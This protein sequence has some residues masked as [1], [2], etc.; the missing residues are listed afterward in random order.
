[1]RRTSRPSRSRPKCASSRKGAPRW[2]RIVSKHPSPQ[3][4]PRFWIETRASSSGITT[5]S[6]HAEAVRRHLHPVL[7]EGLC[8]SAEFVERLPILR[9]RLRI[10]DNA[11]ADREIG[12]FADHRCGAYRDV[13]IDRA[14]PGDIANRPC[15]HAAAVRLQPLDDLHGPRLRGSGDRAAREC[16]AHQVWNR[17]LMPEAPSHDALE[18][19]HVRERAQ[20]F[21]ERHID[22]AEL[23]NFPKVVPLTGSATRWE[24]LT[25]KI[26]PS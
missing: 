26:S 5:P 17:H 12:R 2:I 15:V 11:A 8:M 23:A 24:R 3:R 6:S 7:G 4:N 25:W 16:G 10:G 1:M 19:M 21:Q 9:V 14:I 13:P 18:M 22:T 20:M